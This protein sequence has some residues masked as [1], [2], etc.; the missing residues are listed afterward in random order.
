MVVPNKDFTKILQLLKENYPDAR[1]KLQF[2]NPFQLLISTILSAQCT[3]AQVNKV[4]AG[5]FKKYSGPLDFAKADLKELEKDIRTTGFYRNKAKNIKK[6]SQIIVDKFGG[7][8]PK[9]M[10]ELVSLP[11]V[12]RK[13]A[14]IVLTD[15]FGI[16][17]G[18]AVDTHVLR[19]SKRLGLT[20]KKD[21]VKVEKDLME[22]VPKNEWRIF[23]HLLQAHGR[24]ICKARKPNCDVCFLK[25]LCPSA[26]TFD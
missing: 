22:I 8:V 7:E 20:D 6:A 5:L 15:G 3:D 10:G 1:I 2:R 21:P 4:T 12:A 16:S 14:N 11:G 9:T 26:F 25:D 24:A 17:V 13:T 19:L 23:S 18:I